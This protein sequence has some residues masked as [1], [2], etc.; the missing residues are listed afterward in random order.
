MLK[1]AQLVKFISDL[2]PQNTPTRLCFYNFLRAYPQ[3]DDH[4]TSDL[5]ELFFAYCMDYPHWAGNKN[6]LG[7]EVQFLLENFNSLYQQKFDLSQIR[8][9][10]NMQLIELEH[11]SDQVEVIESYLKTQTESED[12]IRLISDQNKRVV[13]V[14]LKANGGLEVRCFD[15][16]FTIR[17]GQLQPLRR[18]LALFY[19]PELE[20]AH[21]VTQKIEVAPYIT[22][23]FKVENGRVTGA[24]IRGYVFQKLQELKND[25]LQEQTRL[26]HPIKRLEQFFV[27][28]RSD[29]FYQE[30][31]T[32]LERTCALIQQGQ[33]EA[34]RR[35]NMVLNQGESA[36]ENVFVGDKLLTL[37]LKDLKYASQ[38]ARPNIEA[39]ESCLKITP[40]T[41]YDLTN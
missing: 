40:I 9:P 5:I 4:L 33:P 23:H 14:I 26:L 11:F 21:G 2:N 20:L 13:A 30:L 27:D 16:K 31:V 10:Q 37:L 39:N 18:D 22:S 36:L 15:K 3:P 38:N 25:P 35:A 24:L 34:I 41:K 32:L 28:R 17:Q 7:H 19:T 1:V 12:K 6:Q 29:P 8:F